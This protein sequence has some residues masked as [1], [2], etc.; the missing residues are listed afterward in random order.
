MRGRFWGNSEFSAW[1]SRIDDK[2]DTLSDGAGSAN[3]TLRTSDWSL[4]TA[5]DNVGRRFNPALGFV[6]RRDMKSYATNATYN[7]FI[8]DSFFRSYS[9]TA[10]ASL[11]N[12]QDNRKQSSDLGLNGN[13]R[14]RTNDRITWS[15][16]RNF[17]R[18]EESF[19]LRRDV[20]LLP[21]DYVSNAASVGFRTDNSKFF[22]A[23]GNL[24]FSEFFGGDRTTYRVGIGLRTG[25]LTCPLP[26]AR[27][28]QPLSE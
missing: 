19:F 26:M 16:G 11:I 17:E 25:N 24:Q 7:P 18:L 10:S 14:F 9:V 5:Y 13:F 3:L 12:G 2:D 21:G 1:F 8:G 20:E 4:G 27:S 6:R 15:V 22:S 23:N 28:T